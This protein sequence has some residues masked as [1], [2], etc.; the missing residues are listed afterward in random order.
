MILSPS[1]SQI[2][3]TGIGRLLRL[4]IVGTSEYV[5]RVHMPLLRS[6]PRVSVVAVCGR[7]VERTTAFA[8]THGVAQ[9]FIDHREML[10]RAGLDAVV[11]ATP[12]DLHHSMSMAAIEAGLHVLC[13]KPMALNGNDAR[14]MLTRAEGAAVRHMVFFRWRW[15]PAYEQMRQLLE[16]GWIGRPL[17]WTL[18]YLSSGG[19]R[20]GY[21]W[22]SDER[23][24]NGTLGDLGSHM[25]DLAQWLG[26]R[27]ST[28]SADLSTFGD[29]LRDDGSRLLGNDSALVL[30]RFESG[31]QGTIQVSSVTRLG[32]ESQHQGVAVYGDEGWLEVDFP[33]ST[34][35]RLRGA[36]LGRVVPPPDAADPDIEGPGYDD[37]LLASWQTRSVAD[38]L[39]VDSI[40]A[41]RP[42]SPSFYD[43]VRVQDVIDA[44][45][46]SQETRSWVA[47]RAAD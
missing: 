23:R 4:G 34:G 43:G 32:A 7:S 29:K 12:D 18:R 6:H 2:A 42:I 38:R 35:P 28:V 10:E 25:I 40:L 27:I 8:S 47:V 1:D 41:S 45:L 11:I 15:L 37:R 30:F 16:E 44:T 19:W 33:R 14:E 17:Q 5:G 24:A 22:R 46:E 36:S 13:E 3:S 9:A 20:P 26:G 21:S 39:F 31:A